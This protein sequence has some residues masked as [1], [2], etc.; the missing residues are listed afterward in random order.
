MRALLIC[1][2]LATAPTI[3]QGAGENHGNAVKSSLDRSRLLF[4]DAAEPNS[5][6]SQ[7]ILAR[8]AWLNR[9]NQAFFSDPDWPMRLTAAEA[10]AL[11][12][13]ARNPNPRPVPVPPEEKRYLAVV[14]KS[15]SVTGASFRKGQQIVL[16]ALRDYNK[17]GITLV[18][19]QAILLWLDHVKLL[20]EIPPDQGA[21]V[22]V[23]I[24]SARYGFPGKTGYGISGMVQSLVSPNAAGRYEILVSD[25]LLTPSAAQKLNRSVAVVSPYD[26]NTGQPNLRPRKILTVS[27]TIGGLTKT[28]QALE[29]E[30]LLLD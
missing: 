20:R 11:G 23:K 29:G 6:L 1:L 8:I 25:A 18:D 28:K 5:A 7:A 17:R 2:I 10:L 16:E 12:I 15:F 27:Y 4:P 13:R 21:P 9:N 24:E 14:T 26:P 22:L 19:G 30:T 3:L